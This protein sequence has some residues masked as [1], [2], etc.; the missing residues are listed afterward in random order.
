M[1]ENSK[2]RSRKSK[3]VPRA[4]SDS[5]DENIAVM[6][7]EI[8]ATLVQIKNKNILMKLSKPP[9]PKPP[10]LTIKVEVEEFS[11]TREPDTDLNIRIDSV[12]SLA[13]PTAQPV[14]STSKESDLPYLRISNETLRMEFEKLSRETTSPADKRI[15]INVRN[16]MGKNRVVSP[17]TYIDDKLQS[18]LRKKWTTWRNTFK[19][20]R[21]SPV[22]YK[23]D[24]CN[25]AWW[26]LYPFREHMLH[27]HKSNKKMVIQLQTFC[28]ESHVIAY[29]G[30]GPELR[31]EGYRTKSNCWRCGEG[32]AAHMDLKCDK[33]TRYRCGSCM[34]KFYT[35]TL[36]FDHKSVCPL[37]RNS[38]YINGFAENFS[39][40][41]CPIKLGTEL[42]LSNHMLLR[43]SV[44]SDLP[45]DWVLKACTVCDYAY[46]TQTL[47]DC[48]SKPPVASCKYCLQKFNT[49]IYHSIH[50]TFTEVEFPCRICGVLLERQCMELQHLMVH[51]NNYTTLYKCIYC[52]EPKYFPTLYLINKHKFSMHKARQSDTKNLLA[53][54]DMV[55]VPKRLAVS[56]PGF[57][58]TEQQRELERTR[59]TEQS[60]ADVCDGHILGKNEKRRKSITIVDQPPKRASVE[61][62][63]YKHSSEE[64]VIDITLP[65]DSSQDDDEDHDVEIIEN[66]QENVVI[67]IT[68]SDSAQENEVIV[69]MPERQQDNGTNKII[70]NL[71]NGIKTENCQE[72]EIEDIKVPLYK[73]DN[74]VSMK[75]PNNTVVG[76][77]NSQERCNRHTIGHTQGNDNN[78]DN[79]PDNI[80]E[81]FNVGVDISENLQESEDPKE[82]SIDNINDIPPTEINQFD[83]YLVIKE[84]I[85]DC[86]VKTHL[87][88]QEPEKNHEIKTENSVR[89]KEEPLDIVKEEPLDIVQEE[90]LDIVREGPVDIVQ[91][92]AVLIANSNNT[93]N[94]SNNKTLI[95]QAVND[96]LGT[97]LVD[98]KLVMNVP[99]LRSCRKSKGKIIKG[100]AKICYRQ[101]RNVINNKLLANI[102]SEILKNNINYNQ[103]RAAISNSDKSKTNNNKNKLK[104]DIG[105]LR[106]DVENDKLKNNND[107]MKP[108]IVKSRKHVENK[109]LK[110][111]NDKLEANIDK[112]KNDNEN[113]KL[114]TNNDKVG[115]TND[116]LIN[117]KFKDDN[118]KDF[119]SKI[120]QFVIQVKQEVDATDICNNFEVAEEELNFNIKQE[121][122][123]EYIED[124]MIILDPNNTVTMNYEMDPA[125]STSVTSEDVEM[126][127]LLTPELVCHSYKK[128][129]RCRKCNFRGHHHEYKIHLEQEE[130]FAKKKKHG[131]LRKYRVADDRGK[132]LCTKCDGSYQSIYKYIIHFTKVH[133]YAP[134]T[135]PKCFQTLLS[136]QT[137][138]YHVQTHIR[139]NYVNI[140]L[141]KTKEQD[142]EK[143]IRQCKVCSEKVTPAD[144]FKHWENHLEILDVSKRPQENEGFSPSM[145]HKHELKQMLLLLQGKLQ[146][147]GPEDMQYTKLRNCIKCKRRFDR[148]NE[149]KRHFIEHLLLD[150]YQERH[151]Y[152]FLRC[153]ICSQDFQ[154]SER[155]KRHMREHGS[156]PIYKCELCDKSFSDSS[157]F[158]KHKKVHNLSVLICDICKKKF[159]GKLFLEKHIMLHQQMKPLVCQECDKVFYTES[160]YRKHL[161]RGKA[162]FKCPSCHV[163]FPSV[164]EKW[165]HMWDEHKERKV[166]ADCPLCKK[167]YRRLRDVHNHLRSEHGES[168]YRYV[169]DKPPR[170]KRKA[171]TSVN[172][173][174]KTC[175]NSDTKTD[176]K[177][178]K[179]K[180][181]RSGKDFWTDSKSCPS[182]KIKTKKITVKDDEVVVVYTKRN[183]N[184]PSPPGP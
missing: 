167:P 41:L 126:Q 155:Y 109:T 52:T 100:G 133:D 63:K 105:T 177:D 4:C 89:V 42:Q 97:D 35:C 65:D 121:N 163:F 1:E 132:Y 75:S 36:L 96:K 169:V 58:Q 45:T 183:V 92:E 43:H 19:D 2:K 178:T 139:E 22:L 16:F 46:S 157:N 148:K 54:Y 47:H 154:N 151:K 114:K 86:N 146:P 91:E 12:T 94:I 3:L 176:V 21:E 57:I 82:M 125:A 83:P 171:K 181:I 90:P 101:F 23:C 184:D 30:I 166:Q 112:L 9:A 8:E 40:T 77:D 13:Q 142:E 136:I 51:T 162:L 103:L 38:A 88:Q 84:E 70:E 159:T 140:Y 53:C 10:Q 66:P 93:N 129:Y 26:H 71:N 25:K 160:S 107:K 33:S 31:A 34:E 44:R 143:N 32:V 124:D 78:D 150:A 179:T 73:E 106:D 27:R 72:N 141:I 14:P 158:T 130:H 144:F 127:S 79:I 118:I 64:V 128:V 37:Y 67:D 104:A 61:K 76:S 116:E 180:R 108:K 110:T 145:E 39:C 98:A 60:F 113:D 85:I 138:Q 149:C 95:T 153:Q 147:G 165:D 81:R 7:Q 49:H 24:K 62:K 11:E 5:D 173:D 20:I 28:H 102:D 122:L 29:D 59:S 117:E 55:V 182:K 168:R 6:Q 99:K 87:T 175:I 119:E 156:L 123:D 170:S 48:P 50:L 74:D 120:D 17:Y 172:M 68:A 111:D 18:I 134:Q 164:R 131:C 80:Q 137:F 15:E 135:C 161:S 152:G 56:L 69:S 174:T 115:A